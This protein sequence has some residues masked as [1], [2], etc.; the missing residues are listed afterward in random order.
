MLQ[1]SKAFSSYSVDNLDKAKEFY[2]QTL[3]LSV[4]ENEMGIL[5]IDL[6]GNQSLII[7]PKD[8]HRPATFTVLN[9][10]VQNIDKTVDY[11]INNGIE[12]EQYDDFDHDEK[13][14]ARSNGGG[15]S[16]GWFRDPA[17]NIISIMETW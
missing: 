15:P 4:K 5:D 1:S 3:G 11:L 7:Y 12:L 17:G 8:N 14:I 13:G 6:P 10:V 16:I 2:T 9:F